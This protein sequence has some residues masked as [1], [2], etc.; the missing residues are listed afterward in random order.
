MNEPD[1][2]AIQTFCH[3]GRIGVMLE[4]AVQ[5]DY[6]LRTS[7]VQEFA[8]MI[9]VHIAAAAPDNM[10]RLLAQPL[11]MDPSRTVR[12][13]LDALA[14]TLHES[15]RLRRFVR[16]EIGGLEATHP[17]PPDAPEILTAFLGRVMRR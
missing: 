5:T 13:V 10:Q 7:E 15:V 16:W 12:E 8:R 3:Q 11:A 6:A 2:A 4:Y 1:Q 9:A 17:E 14:E